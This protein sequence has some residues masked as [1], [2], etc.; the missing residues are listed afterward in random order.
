MG[1]ASYG[2]SSLNC[3]PPERR[4]I[5]KNQEVRDMW[6]WPGAA[7]PII[8]GSKAEKGHRA[9]EGNSIPTRPALRAK[10]LWQ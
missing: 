7:V 6:L 8:R 9:G 2:A 3:R 5:T 10:Q 4:S 1:L